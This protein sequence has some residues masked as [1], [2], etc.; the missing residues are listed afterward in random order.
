MQSFGLETASC[1]GDWNIAKAADGLAFDRKIHAAGWSF[2][3][4]LQKSKVSDVLGRSWSEEDPNALQRIL[5]KVKQQH[6]NGLEVTGIVAKHCLGVPYPVVTA[7]SHHVQQS[8][9]LD[10]IEVWWASQHNT[11]RARG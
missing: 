3:S 1:C 5:E 6:F 8:C 10:A 9:Q 7:H 4:W 2:F 11:E